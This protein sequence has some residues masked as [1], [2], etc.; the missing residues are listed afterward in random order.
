[1]KKMMLV[2]VCVGLVFGASVKK[3]V[4]NVSAKVESKV[5]IVKKYLI[6]ADTIKTVKIDTI[7][8]VK[9]DTLEIVAS[10]KDTVKILKIDTL[11]KK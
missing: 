1:M 9:Y 2:L 5:R 6:V 11:R 7:V 4:V 8:S 10:V 3:E